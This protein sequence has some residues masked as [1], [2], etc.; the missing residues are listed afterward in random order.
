MILPFLHRLSP[1]RH[2]MQYVIALGRG[3]DIMGIQDGLTLVYYKLY[4]GPTAIRLSGNTCLLL[5]PDL[6]RVLWLW[7]KL[8]YSAAHP[9]QREGV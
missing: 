1:D 2:L 7:D 8:R 4:K 5:I 9:I 6:R 3:V